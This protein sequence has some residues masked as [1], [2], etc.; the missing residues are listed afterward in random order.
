MIFLFL[1]VISEPSFILQFLFI[2]ILKPENQKNF[3]ALIPSHESGVSPF[4]D[5]HF[6]LDRIVECIPENAADIHDI[7]KIKQRSICHAGKRDPM[8]SQYK[9]LLVSTVSSTLFPVLFLCF[10]LPDLILHPVQ[11]FFF[12]FGSSSLLSTAIWCFRS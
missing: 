3:S 10:V 1:V 12:F 9:L 7:H 11:E 5:L 8:L 4:R 6:A 2:I